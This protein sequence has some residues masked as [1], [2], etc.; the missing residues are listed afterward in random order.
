MH[1]LPKS[2]FIV[3]LAITSSATTHSLPRK[4]TIRGPKHHVS[5]PYIDVTEFCGPGASNPSPDRVARN[6]KAITLASAEAAK[7]A[8]KASK[9]KRSLTKREI[10]ELLTPESIQ[11]ETWLHVIRAG[12]GFEE[13]NVWR[14]NVEAQVRITIVQWGGER[15]TYADFFF[16]ETVYSTSQHLPQVKHN[17]HA[18]RNYKHNSPKLVPVPDW[19]SIRPNTY[20]GVW[21]TRQASSGRFPMRFKAGWI[22]YA[23]YLHYGHEDEQQ[24]RRYGTFP[25]GCN[26]EIKY[27]KLGY[28]R[29]CSYC[30]F[31]EFTRNGRPL[32]E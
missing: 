12:D 5:T 7:R 20:L 17:P 2:L 11:V 3:I 29:R 15:V 26:G 10:D 32:D 4:P 25:S 1:L 9:G 14:E 23:E 21:Y 28:T 8:I 22:R 27:F 6:N 16:S 31:Q 30:E 18:R 13:G 19:H 24:L